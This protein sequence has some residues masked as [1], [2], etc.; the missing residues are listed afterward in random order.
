MEGHLNNSPPIRQGY[1]GKRYPHQYRNRENLF[2]A[3]GDYYEFPTSNYPYHLQNSRGRVQ[4]QPNVEGFTRTV[5]DQNRVIQ[6][7]M[8]HPEGNYT[9][10]VR[11]D[12][13]YPAPRGRRGKKRR[14]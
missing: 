13:V 1:K 9:D 4:G 11:A 8:Y 12:E 2:P 14:R 3:G 7:V 6:G 10:F 5:T